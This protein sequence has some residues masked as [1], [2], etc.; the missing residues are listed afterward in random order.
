[1]TVVWVRRNKERERCSYTCL[2]FWFDC[3]TFHGTCVEVS[4]V[5]NVLNVI[6]KNC[7]KCNK[8]LVLNVTRGFLKNLTRGPQTFK[9]EMKR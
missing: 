2:E 1:M 8:L 7:P 6:K 9:F 4:N 5:I 3:L